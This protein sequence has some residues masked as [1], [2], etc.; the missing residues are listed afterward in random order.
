VRSDSETTI[1]ASQRLA[2]EIRKLTFNAPSL[3]SQQPPKRP[4]FTAILDACR[5]DD[6]ATGGAGCAHRIRASEL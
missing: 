6:L 2:A 5:A 3:V 4:V 1:W